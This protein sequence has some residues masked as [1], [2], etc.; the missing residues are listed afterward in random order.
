MEQVAPQDLIEKRSLAPAAP[1]VPALAAAKILPAP[2]GLWYFWS[3]F[4]RWFL[5]LLALEL[6][7]FFLSLTTFVAPAVLVSLFLLFF[8]ARLIIFGLLTSQLF[9]SC[10]DLKT[11]TTLIIFTAGLALLVAGVK[12]FC[13]LELWTF[14]N[15][16]LET[17]W[18]V[19][20]A[21]A[22]FGICYFIKH[23]KNN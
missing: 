10:S 19:I 17:L 15:L 16:I 12:L 3:F 22:V 14:Y 4:R 11:F 5:I 6:F 8:L 2:H 20:Q 18:W 13:L 9:K 7:S 1:S 23:L 21:S